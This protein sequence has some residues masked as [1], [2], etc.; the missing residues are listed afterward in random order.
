MTGHLKIP[1]RY[2]PESMAAHMCVNFGELRAACV[3]LDT[4][5]LTFAKREGAHPFAKAFQD[6][7]LM[8]LNV[9]HQH[10]LGRGA[11]ADIVARKYFV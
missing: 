5:D 7:K 9:D 2:Q 6:V 8:A 3:K 1:V 11:D 4:A 10:R